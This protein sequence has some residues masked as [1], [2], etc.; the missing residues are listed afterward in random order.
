MESAPPARNAIM[1]PGR[2]EADRSTTSSPSTTPI[3]VEGPRVKVT[4]FMWSPVFCGRGRVETVLA[5]GRWK[6]RYAL[7]RGAHRFELDAARLAERLEGIG[8]SRLNER[9]HFVDRK[10]DREILLRDLSQDVVRLRENRVGRG[11]PDAIEQLIQR[12]QHLRLV[13]CTHKGVH[14]ES[15]A[16][17]NELPVERFTVADLRAY[18]FTLTERLLCDPRSRDR[19]RATD[20]RPEDAGHCTDD[21]GIHRVASAPYWKHRLRTRRSRAGTA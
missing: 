11:E 21:R 16:F 2:P 19:G 18:Q 9:A 7:H 8:A 14:D 15:G 6:T 17:A 12:Q 5:R 10:I 3:R 4:S 20:E 13:Q 1:S